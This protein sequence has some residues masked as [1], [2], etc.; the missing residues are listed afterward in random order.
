MRLQNI[1]VQVADRDTLCKAIAEEMNRA[2]SVN[3]SVYY[4]SKD[5]DAGSG[6]DTQKQNAKH[7]SM[8][9]VRR[10]IFKCPTYQWM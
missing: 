3:Y 10:I 1:K 6:L 8:S 7:L 5:T 4:T 9:I 2:D